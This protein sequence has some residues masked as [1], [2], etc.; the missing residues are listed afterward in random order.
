L[1]LLLSISQ[2]NWKSNLQIFVPNLT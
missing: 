1:D 2:I